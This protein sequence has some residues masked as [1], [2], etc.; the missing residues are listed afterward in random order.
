ML[1][2]YFKPGSSSMAVHIALNEIGCPFEARYLSP[3]NN[4]QRTPEYLA[5][6]AEGKVPTLMVD[7]R[8]LTEVAA[9]LFYLARSHAQ[10][11]LLPDDLE[12]QAQVLSWMSFI[13]ATVHP[14]RQKGPENAAKVWALAE[15]RLGART[16]TVGDAYTIADIHLFRLYWRYINFP[17]PVLGRFPA[18]Q[19]HYERVLARPAVR[20]TIEAESAIGYHL[21]P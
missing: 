12:Q 16:W 14:A 11:Q 18:L 4:E 2:L 9:I 15:Q 20:M 1:A 19:A 8:P 7:G 17:P 13:A 10:A 3:L 5:V 6:N 21:P